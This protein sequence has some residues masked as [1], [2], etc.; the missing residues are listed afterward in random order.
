MATF[1][2]LLTR[3]MART[4]IGDAE[5]ARRVGVSRLTLV[6]WKEGVTSRPRHREDVAR[7][8]EVLRLEPEERDEL[9]LAAGFSPESAQAAAGTPARAEEEPPASEPAE[10][11]PA[12]PGRGKPPWRRKGFRIAGAAVAALL[13]AAIAGALAALLVGGPGLP[14]ADDDESL[15]VMAPFVNYTG[16]QQGFNV[17]G[18]LKQQIDREILAAGLRQVRT[19][20]WPDEIEGEDAALEAGLK[21][22]ATIVIWGGIRQRQGDRHL[23]D[24]EEDDGDA[25]PAGRGPGVL[26]LGAARNGQRVTDG[27]GAPRGAS[28]AGATVPGAGGVRPGE[29]GA[30]PRDGAAALG[31][32]GAGWAEVPAWTRVPSAGT[33]R[34]STRR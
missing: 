29:G 17:R 16:G 11:A 33:W 34:T 10:A 7:L 14:E 22:G 25:R 12:P 18:R 27:G 24:P 4:G 20:E 26:A 28:D 1:A 30:D 32:P 2:E 6:R 21:S 5:L 19:A 9:L 13:L 31:P 23:H 15:I 3:Y 8:A